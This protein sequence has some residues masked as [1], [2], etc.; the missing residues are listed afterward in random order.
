MFTRLCSKNLFSWAAIIGSNF[1]MGLN[2]HALLGYCEI[3]ENRI[4]PNNFLIPE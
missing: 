4:F 2:E 1:R 3:L